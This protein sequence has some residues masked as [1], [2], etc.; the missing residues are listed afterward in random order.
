MPMIEAG[1][2]RVRYERAGPEGAP[3]VVLSH[4]LGMDLSMWD[5]QVGPLAVSFH[6]L[7]HDTRGHGRT[8]VTPGPYSLEQLARDV[9]GLMDGLGLRRAHFCGLSLGGQ[10]G[11][12]LGAH[13]PER[14]ERLVLCNTGARIG[15]AERW[16]ERIAAVRQGGMASIGSSVP[17]R[18]FSPEFRASSPGIVEN[19]RA[20]F[21]ATPPEGYAGCCA[22]IRDAD[23]HPGLAAIRSPTLVIAGSQDPATPPADGRC[24]AAAIPNARYHE[25]QA[26]HLSCLEAA[27]GFTSA[28]AGFLS[29]QGDA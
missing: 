10:I 14:I 11:M 6:V 19:A 1:D 16:D 17:E 27:D 9:L 4:S 23:L 28:L 13:A 7:R 29:G 22:A 8:T 26:S 2:L 21:E 12:W 3:W 15:T 5:E 20:V 18:W 24:L 25:L